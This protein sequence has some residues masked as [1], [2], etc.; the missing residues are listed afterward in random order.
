MNLDLVLRSKIEEAVLSL[1]GQAAGVIQLQPTNQEFEG[2][3]TIVCFPLTKLSR[4]TPEETARVL[5]EQLLKDSQLISKYNVVKG[6][7]NL[8]IRDSVWLEIFASIYANAQFG[9]LP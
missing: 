9:K 1:F 6:F 3:H 5:G 8:V 7:L 4:K 2:S